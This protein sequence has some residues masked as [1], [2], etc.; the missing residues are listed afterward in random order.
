LKA[1]ILRAQ[2]KKQR[3]IAEL[4]GVSDRTVRTYLNRPEKRPSKR[5]RASKLDPYR[6]FIDATLGNDL[7][8]SHEVLIPRLKNMGYDRRI[9]LLRD[10]AAAIGVVK[11]LALQAM[12][13][14]AKKE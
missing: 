7:A 2:G 8:C 11:G 5:L 9:S 4:L 3:E 6:G 12:K 13:A 1:E 10:Y 14:E